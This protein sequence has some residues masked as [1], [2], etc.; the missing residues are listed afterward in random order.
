MSSR[1]LFRTECFHETTRRTRNDRGVSMYPPSLRVL[2]ACTLL[3]PASC[4]G[5]GGGGGGG[6]RDLVAALAAPVSVVPGAS[7]TYTV[8]GTANGGTVQSVGATLTLPAT[9][10][11]GAITGGGVAS[12]SA[13]TWP[14]TASLA[15]GTPLSYTVTVTAPSVGPLDATLQLTTTSSESTPNNRATRSTLL[16]FTVLATLNG[17]S[18]GD[19]FGY[20]ADTI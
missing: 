13:I 18:P 9:V 16:G 2:C 1:G 17:E 12:G 7:Y 15:P 11:I 3:L 10:A 8:T 5:G 4:G 19:N 20:V 6:G 14:T